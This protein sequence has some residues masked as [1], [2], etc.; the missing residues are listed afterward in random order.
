MR[1]R[2]TVLVLVVLAASAL[3]STS[4]RAASG[5]WYPLLQAINRTR[6]AHGLHRVLPAPRLHWAARWH[7]QDMLA[8]DYFAH[9]SPTGSTLYDRIVHSG[10][11]TSGQWWAGETLAW[12]TGSAATADSVVR[13]WLASPEHRAILLSPLYRFVGLGRAQGRFLGYANAVV[14]TADW[15]HR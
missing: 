2:L 7:S 6:A 11:R 12:A 5:H 10:F 4:A 14:W 9:T 3:G 13:M 1:R 8:R 15:G